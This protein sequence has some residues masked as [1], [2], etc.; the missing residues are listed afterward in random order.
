MDSYNGGSM[1]AFIGKNC[2][3]IGADRRLGANF[4]TVST[5]F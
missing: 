1:V 5:N 2:V 4:Q 3:C